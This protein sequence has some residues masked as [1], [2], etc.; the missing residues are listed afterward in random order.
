M[1]KWKWTDEVISQMKGRCE[2]RS[3]PPWIICPCSSMVYINYN[4]WDRFYEYQGLAESLHRMQF[5]ASM[6]NRERTRKIRKRPRK[7]TC[8]GKSRENTH[9][10]VLSRSIIIYY[11]VPCNCRHTQGSTLILQT[12]TDAGRDLDWNVF[13]KWQIMFRIIEREKEHPQ[14]GW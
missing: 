1:N 14:T 6:E 4:Y 10:P 7:T 2:P 3:N 13:T 9:S 8:I 5:Q 12:L 11:S